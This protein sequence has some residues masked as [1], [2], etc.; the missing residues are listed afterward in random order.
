MQ[1]S[2]AALNEFHSRATEPAGAALLC[3]GVCRAL[4]QLG[5]VS[6]LEFP[7]A[8]GRRADVIALGRNGEVMIVEVKSSLADF[9][10]DRKWPDYWEFCDRLYFAVGEDFPRDVLPEEC[11]LLVADGY[12]AAVLRDPAPRPL[13]AARR[14]ALTLRFGF[15]A[16][17]RLRRLTDPGAGELGL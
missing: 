9:R 7:L 5:Y 2:A 17:S 10:A 11:G 4:D 13:A 3:R 15:A 12:G 14:K 8:N 6:L 16:A 1:D